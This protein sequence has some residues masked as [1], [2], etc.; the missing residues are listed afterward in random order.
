MRGHGGHPNGHGRLRLVTEPATT[1]IPH[2]LTVGVDDDELRRLGLRVVLV[3]HCHG[4]VVVADPATMTVYVSVAFDGPTRRR[5]FAAAMDALTA[6]AA[7]G[8]APALRLA[9]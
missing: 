7:R 4:R 8:T 5:A 2:P 1:V 9:T 6:H 3:E